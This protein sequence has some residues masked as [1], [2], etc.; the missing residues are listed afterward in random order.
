MSWGAK[1]QINAFMQYEAA[2]YIFW[3]TPLI[4]P[5]IGLGCKEFLQGPEKW[6]FHSVVDA[7]VFFYP[8]TV[9]RP[10]GSEK[11]RSVHSLMIACLTDRTQAMHVTDRP[12]G[13]QTMS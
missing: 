10:C 1:M 11:N 9:A 2:L 5:L 6:Y 4:A 13:F 7:G 3:L 8:I 12:S